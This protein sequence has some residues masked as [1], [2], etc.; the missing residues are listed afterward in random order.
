MNIYFLNVYIKRLFIIDNSIPAFPSTEYSGTQRKKSWI[1]ALLQKEVTRP[2]ESFVSMHQSPTVFESHTQDLKPTT[3]QLT[4]NTIVNGHHR[5]YEHSNVIESVNHHL[6]STTHFAPTVLPDIVSMTTDTIFSHYRQPE[7]PIPGPMYLIIEGHSKVKTYGGPST[8]SGRHEPKFVPVQSTVD[9]VVVRVVN[10]EDDGGKYEVRHLHYKQPTPED[11]EAEE[12]KTATP[13]DT[14]SK[15][16]NVNKMSSL[17]SLL[18][19]SFGD[20]FS[21]KEVTSVTTHESNT[22]TPQT[23]TSLTMSSINVDQTNATKSLTEPKATVDTETSTVP[24]KE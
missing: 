20:F 2:Q 8:S 16:I 24:M 5:P 3:F 23:A 1:Q 17:L 14:K 18:D 13:L 21:A 11:L 12:A 4:T 10:E 9:P 22:I 7:K 19:T 15:P 6:D